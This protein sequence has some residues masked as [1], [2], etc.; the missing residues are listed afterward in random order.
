VALERDRALDDVDAYG[1]VLRYVLA[2]G[3]DVN[4]ALVA[5]GAAEPFFYHGDR[6]RHADA[7]LAAARRARALR[8]GLWRACPAAR[9]DPLRG[10][11][12]GRG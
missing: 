8:V 4:L 5:V 9:L 6:G 7:L 11:L 1:R 12:T 10:A 2:G 3:R